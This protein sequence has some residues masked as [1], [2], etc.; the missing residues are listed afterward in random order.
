[1]TNVFDGHTCVVYSGKPTFY[2]IN[3]KNRGK[4]VQLDRVDIAYCFDTLLDNDS[5]YLTKTRRAI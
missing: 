3:D 2:Y 5:M 1:M 4:I